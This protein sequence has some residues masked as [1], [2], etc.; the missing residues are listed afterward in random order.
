MDFLNVCGFTV[1]PGKNLEFQAWVRANAAALDKAAPEGIALVGIYT[2]IFTS[3]KHSG[4]YRII[5]R[6]DS[7][8]AMD[9][10]TTA[11]GENPELARLMEEL[12]NFFDVRIGVD[13]SDELLKSVLDVTIWSDHAED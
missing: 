3:E 10:F 5:W 11:M 7:Y 8:G 12:G 4:D 13:H 9:R 6:F 2:S 1:P